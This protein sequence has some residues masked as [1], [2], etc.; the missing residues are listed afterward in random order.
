MT[1][2]PQHKN[3]YFFFGKNQRLPKF[4]QKYP[5]LS[6]FFGF[7]L[8]SNFSRGKGV[9]GYVCALRVDFHQEFCSSSYRSRDICKKPFLQKKIT[10]SIEIF[11]FY[12]VSFLIFL[13]FLLKICKLWFNLSHFLY[14]FLFFHKLFIFGPNLL[15]TS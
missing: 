5:F 3:W 15:K 1:S 8:K 11:H 10:Y 14:F 13:R 2:W 9:Q 7:T 4:Y 6:N 12:L